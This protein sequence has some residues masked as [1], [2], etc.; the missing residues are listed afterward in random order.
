M[1]QHL[2]QT[3]LPSVHSASHSRLR[4]IQNQCDVIVMVAV[5][6]IYTLTLAVDFSILVTDSG[7]V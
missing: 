6:N 5:V 4:R 3:Q 1:L 2:V 7:R